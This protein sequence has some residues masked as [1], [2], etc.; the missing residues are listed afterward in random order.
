MVSGQSVTDLI[1]WVRQQRVILDADLARIYGVATA[2]LNQQVKRNR[3]R[4]PDD[5]AFQ[6]TREELSDLMLQ[7]ATSKPGRGGRRKRPYAFTE[8]GAIMA[9]NVL[10]SR[11]AVHM[12][13]FVVRAFL[14]MRETLAQNKELA[15]KLS[16][17]EHRL[18]ER[19]D[20]HEKAIIHVLAEIRKLMDPPSAPQPERRQIGFHVRGESGDRGRVLSRRRKSIEPDSLYKAKPIANSKDPLLSAHHDAVLYPK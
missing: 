2:R 1:R 14:K 13:V 19:L 15:A 17:L 9:A 8:H 7:S 10:H 12:S 3:E 20:V 5:F 16:E 6:L 11:R 4:F 18:T